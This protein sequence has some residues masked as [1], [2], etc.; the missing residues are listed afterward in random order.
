MLPRQVLSNGEGF[1]ADLA[2]ALAEGSDLCVVD[3][4]SSVVDR[5][6]AKVASHTVQRTVRKRGGKFVAVSCHYDIIDWL[7]PDWVLD[8]R[9]RG[10]SWRHL[11]RRPEIQL[12]IHP[13]QR[14]LWSAFSR[15]HY[16]NPNL[17]T[18]AHCYAAYVDGQ[19]VA[20]TSYRHFPHRHTRNIKIGHRLVV[21]PDW[22]GLGIGGRLDDWLGQK[23]YEEGFRY[24]NVVAHPALIRYY[25]GSPRW[26]SLDKGQKKLTTTSKNKT[27]RARALDPRYLGTRSFEYVP[28]KSS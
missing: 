11:Q 17:H 13:A 3:E 6:V 23:L 10:F 16:M 22:Q 26:K 28:P 9:D 2:R 7:Q 19:P 18:A 5:Q 14:G 4:F 20:F 8:M 1:R 25:L 12:D 15:Y 27:L 21:L 24:H